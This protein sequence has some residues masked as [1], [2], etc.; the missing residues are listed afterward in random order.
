MITPTEPEPMPVPNKG[1]AIAEEVIEDLRERMR[2][3]TAKYGTPLQAF[4]GRDAL[5]DLY[6]ELLDAVQ[7]LRQVI[8]ERG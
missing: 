4:N 8:D 7:Y 5:V 3:G 2:Q 6:Q 1:N